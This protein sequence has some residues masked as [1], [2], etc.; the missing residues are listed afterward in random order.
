MESNECLLELFDLDVAEVNRSFFSGVYLKTEETFQVL[1]VRPVGRRYSVDPG[2]Y[3]PPFGFD[4]NAIP[5]L[6]VDCLAGFF[7]RV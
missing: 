6:V 4:G 2:F 1:V 7:M 3:N 5:S